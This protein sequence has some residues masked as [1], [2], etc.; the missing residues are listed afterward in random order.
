MRSIGKVSKKKQTHSGNLKTPCDAA[1]CF[2]CGA[3]T[4]LVRLRFPP[5]IIRGPGSGEQ[6]RLAPLCGR[7]RSMFA[8][9]TRA[10]AE[11]VKSFSAQ[12]WGAPVGKGALEAPVA[13]SVIRRAAL[14]YLLA[15][16][17]RSCECGVDKRIRE[18]LLDRAPQSV[19]VSLWYYPE[20][21]TSVGHGFGFVD[22]VNAVHADSAVLLKAYP[23]AIM[24]TLE[25]LE[26]PIPGPDERSP[27]V[28]LSTAFVPTADWPDGTSRRRSVRVTTGGGYLLTGKQ[29]ASPQGRSPSPR[30]GF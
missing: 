29:Q 10:L 3:A 2:V 11:L 16:A 9:E 8:P 27:L 19:N 18:D 23:I 4:S 24:G 20:G 30:R 17:P 22:K 25:A 26:F 7:C 13:G 6:A 1:A 5:V 21:A 15:S 14:L 28:V 12:L